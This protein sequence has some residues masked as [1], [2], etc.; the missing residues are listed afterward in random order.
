[1]TD[2]QIVLILLAVVFVMWGYLE[3]AE[4]VRR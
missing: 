4:R 2:I 3:L 1:M